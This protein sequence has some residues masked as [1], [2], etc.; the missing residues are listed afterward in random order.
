M[1]KLIFAGILLSLFMMACQ[2]NSVFEIQDLEDTSLKNDWSFTSDFVNGYQVGMNSDSTI[3]KDGILIKRWE[4]SIIGS[5]KSHTFY[6]E[7][8]IRTGEFTL[9]L[10]DGT[11]VHN[12]ESITTRG[13]NECFQGWY[14]YFYLN[15]PFISDCYNDT[16]FN[17]HL[18][19]ENSEDNVAY[20]ASWAAFSVCW[21]ADQL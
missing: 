12:S 11:V 3:E 10:D 15:C 5:D 9:K 17:D 1:N 4:L 16:N 13:F 20:W 18:F 8:N 21:S 14:Y 6:N 2:E 7:I 19:P